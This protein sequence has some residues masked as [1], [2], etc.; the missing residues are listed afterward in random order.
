MIDYEK[1]KE[2]SLQ[3]NESLIKILEKRKKFI[4]YFIHI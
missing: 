3:N 2:K 4:T 1:S